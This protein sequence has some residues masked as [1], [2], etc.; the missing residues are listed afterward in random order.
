MSRESYKAKFVNYGFE[1]IDA[2]D[3][4]VSSAAAAAVIAGKGI[5]K[6]SPQDQ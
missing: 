1:G 4:L 6:A 3:I 5:D 2:K